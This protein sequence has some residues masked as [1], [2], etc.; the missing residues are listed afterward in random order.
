[1]NQLDTTVP[2]V[3]DTIILLK[4]NILYATAIEEEASL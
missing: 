1:M 4:S 3:V 2:C